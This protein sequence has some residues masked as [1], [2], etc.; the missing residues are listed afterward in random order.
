MCDSDG[1]C[2][3]DEFIK[4]LEN[5][6]MGGD[7]NMLANKYCRDIAYYTTSK[8]YFWHVMI[9][10]NGIGIAIFGFLIYNLKKNVIQS[11]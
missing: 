6:S 11:K 10:I 8:D 2:S 9:F 5:N 7:I 1:L 4:F 3:Y